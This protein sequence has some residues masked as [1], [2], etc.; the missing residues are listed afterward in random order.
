MD[1]LVGSD[2]NVIA[3][4]GLGDDN[5]IKGVACPRNVQR[6]FNNVIEWFVT[7][8]QPSALDQIGHDHIDGGVDAT[9]V[10]QILQL[11]PHHWRDHPFVLVHQTLN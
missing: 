1:G 8:Y 11:Q 7:N 9:D 2:Q 3:N 10:M 5:P 4:G 6:L